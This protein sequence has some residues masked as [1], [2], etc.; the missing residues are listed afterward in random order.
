MPANKNYSAQ[1]TCEH[2]PY[3]IVRLRNR[4]DPT[5]TKIVLALHPIAT[6]DPVIMSEVISSLLR[7]EKTHNKGEFLYNI[8]A[9]C[10]D[11]QVAVSWEGEKKLSVPKSMEFLVPF[12]TRDK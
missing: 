7:F 3:A 10:S 11:A 4:E 5:D 9:E 1:F 2:N 8:V 12:L 6:E